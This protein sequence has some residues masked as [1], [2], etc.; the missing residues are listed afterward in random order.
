M[1]HN[2]TVND[3]INQCRH[4]ILAIAGSGVNKG[5]DVD[6]TRL[7]RILKKLTTGKLKNICNK[8]IIEKHTFLNEKTWLFIICWQLSLD[9]EETLAILS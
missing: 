4:M 2:L 8:L 7:L 6:L 9:K 5:T 1:S 3:R